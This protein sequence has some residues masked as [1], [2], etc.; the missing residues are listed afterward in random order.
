[1]FCNWHFWVIS[2]HCYT[3]TV[4]LCYNLACFLNYIQYI[5]VPVNLLHFF[6]V[7]LLFLVFFSFRENNKNEITYSSSLQLKEMHIF[8]QMNQNLWNSWSFFNVF[9]NQTTY[10]THGP[11]HLFFCGWG[12]TLRLSGHFIPWHLKGKSWFEAWL[13]RWSE[14]IIWCVRITN[15][16]WI[17]LQNIN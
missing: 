8:H 17:L 14:K 10:L 15:L 5:S 12:L 3:C 9:C 1:M 6:P 11:S 4:L 2:W 7:K 16:V 13:G